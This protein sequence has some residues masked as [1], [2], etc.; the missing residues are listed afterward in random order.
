MKTFRTL[1][2][3]GLSMMLVLGSATLFTGQ[4]HAQFSSPIHDVDDAARQPVEFFADVSFADGSDS[5]GIFFNFIVPAGKRLVIETI[6]AEIFVPVGQQ[7]T[8]E[9]STE[10][11]NFFPFVA[12]PFNSKFTNNSLSEDEYIATIP[13]RMYSD[14]GTPPGGRIFRN[15]TQ[16]SSTLGFVQCFGYL[17]NLP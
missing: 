11:N 10:L 5:S 13:V 4:A 17:V 12:L 2:Q 1:I 6:S 14:P 3:S 7:V 8:A 16:G 9:V 15:S